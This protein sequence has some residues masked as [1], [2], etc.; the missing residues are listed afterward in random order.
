[1]VKV[2][3]SEIGQTVLATQ[4]KLPR[5]RPLRQP[6]YDTN[7][8]NTT[9]VSYDFFKNVSGKTEF[10]TNMTQSGQLGTPNQFDLLGLQF[11]V[12][13]G[14]SKADHDLIYENGLLTWLFGNIVWL[15]VPLTK[16]PEGVGLNG[17]IST[18]VTAT[19]AAI[20]SNG[21]P[22]AT[23]FFNMAT[24]DR[25]GIRITSNEAFGA[26]LQ[27]RSALSGLS[28][29]HRARLYALGILYSQL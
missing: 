11:E 5:L 22:V 12:A 25:K 26:R 17:A 23:N 14:V 6:L 4:P 21:M 24:I 8:I 27:L 18:T 28:A 2:L 1:M 13:R 10:D 19:T 16:I 20:L 15:K 9:D 3:E 7:T 29:S